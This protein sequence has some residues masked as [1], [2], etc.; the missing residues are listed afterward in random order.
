MGMS[1]RTHA[2]TH[3]LTCTHAPFLRLLL[4]STNING[5]SSL[6]CPPM[7]SSG[8]TS[9]HRSVCA[10]ALTQGPLMTWLLLL[11]VFGYT[12][13]C[14]LAPIL[15]HSVHRC[16]PPHSHID[17]HSHTHAL[18]HVHIHTHLHTLIHIFTHS[19][20]YTHLFMLI[21]IIYSPEPHVHMASLVF[22]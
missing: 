4:Y 10:Q 5:H 2:S 17:T 9:L 3:T 11:Q 8:L 13:G 12:A 22:T 1:T 15:C 14:V 21:S 19:H 6:V 18:T 16:P 20:S 7:L